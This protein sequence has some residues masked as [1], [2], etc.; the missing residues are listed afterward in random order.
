[1]NDDEPPK[2]NKAS[3]YL[4]P[5]NP[6]DG[7]LKQHVLLGK[8]RKRAERTGAVG[9]TLFCILI[10]AL[11]FWTHEHADYSLINKIFG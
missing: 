7:A 3:I 8:K 5:K 2:K 6:L 11:A 10:I 1:M 9:M 4:E